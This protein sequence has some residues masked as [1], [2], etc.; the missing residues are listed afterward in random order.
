MKNKGIVREINDNSIKIELFK[1][2]ACASCSQ[3]DSKSHKTETF[4]YDKNDLKLNEIVEFE[5]EDKSLL[6]IGFITY[7]SPIVFMFSFYSIAAYFNLSENKRIISSFLGLFF[8]FF[9]LYFLD[10]TKGKTFLAKI[11]I[12][13]ENSLWKNY[14]FFY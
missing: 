13:K 9:I 6:K 12:T 3:C 7:L 8:S 10:K 14:C 11:T 2:G 4:F 5:I 1:D